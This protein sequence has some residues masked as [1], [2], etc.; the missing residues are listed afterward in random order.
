MQPRARKKPAKREKTPPANFDGAICAGD[1]LRGALGFLHAQ[2]LLPRRVGHAAPAPL[3]W[4]RPAGRAKALRPHRFHPEPLPAQSKVRR[5]AVKRQRFCPR[6]A[7]PSDASIDCYEDMERFHLRSAAP[8]TGEIFYVGKGSSPPRAT[9]CRLSA[10]FAGICLYGGPP[11]SFN[12]ILH[13]AYLFAGTCGRNPLPLHRPPAL[14]PGFPFHASGSA[15]A[16]K[17]WQMPSFLHK[18]R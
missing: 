3:P 12:G 15:F 9:L 14:R 16:R 6:G 8:D 10:H 2:A 5:F 18:R 11:R 17:K 7:A 1:K 13:K 4:T